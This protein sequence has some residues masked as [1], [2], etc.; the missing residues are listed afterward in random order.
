MEIFNKID[1]N[2]DGFI[3]VNDY[4]NALKA[5]PEVF[6]W[7]ELLNKEAWIEKRKKPIEDRNLLNVHNA[8]K[9]R[10]KVHEVL[11]LLEGKIFII[12][13]LVATDLYS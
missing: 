8:R 1:I 3:D 9:L 12:M 7:F 13:C 2:K 5:D 6:E 11:D 4:K 10:K